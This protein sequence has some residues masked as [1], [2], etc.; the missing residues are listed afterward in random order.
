MD[1]KVFLVVIGTAFLAELGDKSQVLTLMYTST[2]Q[3]SPLVV[4]IG[5]STALVLATG[6]GV[7]AGGALA[8]FVSPRTL[9]WLSGL[10]FLILGGF[11][12]FKAATM[13][14]G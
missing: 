2:K 4:F 12:L 11:T 1:W 3:A 10:G 8:N 9:A 13:Q 14:A 7:I 5:V 6:V